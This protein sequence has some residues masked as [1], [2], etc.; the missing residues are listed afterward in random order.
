MS[1]ER[2]MQLTNDIYEIY[3]DARTAE[4]RFVYKKLQGIK[5]SKEAQAVLD[6]AIELTEKSFKFR[7]VFN[8]DYPEY[9]ILNWDCGWYQIKALLKQYMPKE[10]KEF[11]A[12]FK[13]LSNKMRPMVYDLGFLK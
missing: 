4:E 3:E 6:K 1:R 11:D 5:L 12:L 9:Q 13:Q 7:T 10:L 8:D 2:V